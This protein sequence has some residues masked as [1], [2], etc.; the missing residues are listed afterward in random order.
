MNHRWSRLA[1]HADPPIPSGG[2]TAT[3][4]LFVTCGH[5]C[6][7]S[8]RLERALAPEAVRWHRTPGNVVPPFGAGFP[9]EE[10]VIGDAAAAAIIVCGH[11][12]CAVLDQLLDGDID[13]FLLRDWLGLAE[14]ARRVVLADT[15]LS[16][17]LRGRALVEHNLRAQLAH[18][19]THPRVAA[20]PV[21]LLAW[22]YDRL[23]DRLLC[24]GPGGAFDRLAA[25]DPAH[26]RWLRPGYIRGCRPAPPGPVLSRQ[27][28]YLA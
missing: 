26:N 2:S 10:A 21:P 24:Q 27:N 23:A 5:D 7:P 25:L 17:T 13:D 4:P 16:P 9:G 14:A 8:D 11:S 15:S 1:T 18:L 20:G 6:F 3:G 12:P 19:R 22:H 28:R